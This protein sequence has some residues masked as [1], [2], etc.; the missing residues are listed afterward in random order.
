[1]NKWISVKERL[2]D[3]AG[4]YMVAIDYRE[5]LRVSVATYSETDDGLKWYSWHEYENDGATEGITH[6]MPM[7]ELPEELERTG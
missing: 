4:Y 7:P 6:W 1:M 5:E 2:P 3:T